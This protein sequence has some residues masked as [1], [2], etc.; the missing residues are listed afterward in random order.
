MLLRKNCVTIDLG[1]IRNN[2]RILA[3]AVPK[4]VGVMPVVKAD[5]YGHGIVNVTR[6]VLLEG[7]ACVAVAIA[8]EG[9]QL[10]EN[11]IC[12]E[13]LVL[14][15]ATE[16]AAAAAIENELTQTVFDPHMVMTLNQTAAQIGKI[17][18]VHVKVDTG[19]GRIGLRTDEEARALAAALR[20]AEHVEATGIYTHFA[21]ADGSFAETGMNGF[22]RQQLTRFE[23]LKACFPPTL[24]AHAANSA[25]SLLTHEACFQMVRQGIVLYGCPPVKTELPFRPALQWESE[26]S[27][28]KWIAKGENVG[29]GLAFTA[30]RDMRIATV[31]VGYGDG[32]RRSGSN[33]AQMLIGGKRANVVGR[34]CMDQTMVDVTAIEEAEPGAP[35]MLIG[36]QGEEEIRAEELAGWWDTISYEALLAATSRVPRLYIGE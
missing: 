9:V 6:A 36:R 20:A 23:R 28:V 11:G 15:A 29:Y 19:M 21:D 31:A 8:E 18:R 12:A 34:I 1:A 2:Y 30:P 14:G 35:A 24:A 32:Y 3:N 13:I 26:V 25:M 4:G 27:H 22:S 7:A 33:R 16:R 10:R 5:A 17:A